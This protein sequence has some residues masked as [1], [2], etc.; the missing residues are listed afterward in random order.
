MEEYEKS[1]SA[2]ESQLSL[3]KAAL[4]FAEE[5]M[6]QQ[7]VTYA[8][9]KRRAG[10][11][12]AELHHRVAKLSDRETSSEAYIRDLESKMKSSDEG[13]N[14]HQSMLADLRKDLSRHKEAAR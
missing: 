10:E 3:T 11:E 9:E 12:L 4:T 2:L 13:D 6:K 1:L 14:A 7:E 5:E 8:E